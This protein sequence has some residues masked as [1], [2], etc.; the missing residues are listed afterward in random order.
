MRHPTQNE[1]KDG[2]K[3]MDRERNNESDGSHK[4]TTAGCPQQLM[5]DKG[6]VSMYV[7]VPAVH[8]CQY[9]TS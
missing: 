2:E 9:R 3:E 4:V 7:N 1:M 8:L 5:D 6:S